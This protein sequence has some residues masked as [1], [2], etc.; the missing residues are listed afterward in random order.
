MVDKMMKYS[1]ILLTS[2]KDGF[3]E[4]LQELGVV[5]ISR[6]VKPVDQ[7][8][9]EML[10]KAT[11]ARKVL[12]ILESIDYAKDPDAEAISKTT[13]N[14]EGDPVD[15]TEECRKRLSELK[16]SLSAA[17]KQFKARLPWGEYDKNA[18]DGLTGLGYDIRYYIVDAKR[19]D[20]NW[21]ELYPLHVVEN[22]GKKVWFVTVTP[23]GEGY[24]F[25]VQDTVAPEG[26]RRHSSRSG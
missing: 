15:F 6:S 7:D 11:R 23:K 9:A 26:T 18:L 25:P 24:Q 4:Q 21:G 10:E 5:D 13:V 20:E 19:F 17:E 22:N 12:E 16:T 14:V 3:L 8:S 2:E 1:F